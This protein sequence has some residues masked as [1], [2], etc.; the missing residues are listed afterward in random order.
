MVASRTTFPALLFVFPSS[1]DMALAVALPPFSTILLLIAMPLVTRR[2]QEIL[3]RRLQPFTA[4]S[5]LSFLIDAFIYLP[6]WRVSAWT[7]SP[8]RRIPARWSTSF[9]VSFKIQLLLR[10]S[11]SAGFDV[12]H[13]EFGKV[14]V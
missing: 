1:R 5:V 10:R 2:P 14:C 9:H 4:R 6:R 3:P 12:F 7:S 13:F 8:F 11:L